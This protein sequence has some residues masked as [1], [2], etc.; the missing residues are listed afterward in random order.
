MFIEKTGKITAAMLG[1]TGKITAAVLILTMSA[2]IV[3]GCNDTKITPEQEGWITQ[4]EQW[5]PDDEFTYK[6]HAVRLMGRNDGV[7]TF[8]SKKFPDQYFELGEDNGVLV[9]SYPSVYHKAAAEEYFAGLAKDA[10]ECDHVL[11]EYSTS[12]LPCEYVSDDEFIDKYMVN[13]FTLELHYDT[14]QSV[15]QKQMVSRVLHFVD[16]LD[17]DATLKIYVC[18]GNASRDTAGTDANYTIWV[19][20]GNVTLRVRENGERDSEELIGNMNLDNALTIY[21]KPSVL[22][23]LDEEPDMDKLREWYPEFF[24]DDLPMK[25]VVVYVWQMSEDSYSFGLM[26]GRNTVTTDE[27][28]WELAGR[29][30]TLNEAKALL[31]ECG[32][33]QDEISVI[34]VVQ[35]ISSYAYEIDDEYR[36][37][38]SGFFG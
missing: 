36:E 27:E 3:T 18:C 30:L 16:D 32:V 12:S 17:E 24:D 21:G 25:G 8:R 7:I 20:D 2:G 26:Q 38:V 29:P 28:I 35:P 5:Y 9:S 14:L 33:P 11:A 6:G 15:S 23:E 10:F 19:K 4:M 22:Y 31:N 13:T 37:K 1:K 34:P